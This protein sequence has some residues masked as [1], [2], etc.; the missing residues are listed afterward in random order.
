MMQDYQ[1]MSEADRAAR[2]FY[3]QP[4]DIFAKQVAQIC[5]QDSRLIAVF[6]RTRD[7]YLSDKVS[8]SCGA[9]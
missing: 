5:A 8:K 9:G 1:N 4:A 7:I 3:G 6:E 2:S